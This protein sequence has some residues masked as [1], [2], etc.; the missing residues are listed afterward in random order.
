[1]N[2]DEIV[3][4][5]EFLQ[6]M[7]TIIDCS[8]TLQHAKEII[9]VKYPELIAYATDDVIERCSRLYRLSKMLKY[10]MI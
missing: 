1:M 3:K 10:K 6:L 7:H 9:R 8:V 5:P 2:K 4:S